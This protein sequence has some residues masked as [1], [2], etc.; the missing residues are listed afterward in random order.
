MADAFCVKM[1]T[2]NVLL[3]DLESNLRVVK[4]AVGAIVSGGGPV[5]KQV[6]YSRD[7]SLSSNEGSSL[8]ASCKPLYSIIDWCF[9]EIEISAPGFLFYFLFFYFI[10]IFFFA[11]AAIG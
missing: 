5:L 4:L 1:F 9:K 11:I 8:H 3:K 2:V 7:I 6:C 10:I